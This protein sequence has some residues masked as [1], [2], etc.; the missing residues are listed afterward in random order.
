MVVIVE[1]WK[2]ANLKSWK[3][4]HLFSHFSPYENEW[5]NKKDSLL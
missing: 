3:D 1:K 2:I 5:N 4:Q